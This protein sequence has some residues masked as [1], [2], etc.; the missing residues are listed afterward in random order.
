MTVRSSKPK[1]G[2]GLASLLGEMD[3][4]D[5]NPQQ[6][7]RML[8]VAQLRPGPFQPRISVDTEDLESLAGSIKASG[9][10][11]P[12]LAREDSD[13][14]DSWQIVA[15]E[16]RW[17]AAQMAGLHEVPCIIKKFSD[18]DAL[19]AGLVENL[20]RRDLDAIEEAEGYRRLGLEFNLTQEAIADLI[21]KSRAHIANAMR[22]LTLPK[23]VQADVRN[24]ALSAGHA[25]ALV[26]HPNPEQAALYI[27][28][29]GLNVRQAEALAQPATRNKPRAKDHDLE[30]LERELTAHLGLKVVIAHGETGGQVRISYR[31]LDQ[32]D[33]ILKLLR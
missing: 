30:A 20:Q 9:I 21:G 32:L 19:A 29:R 1:L 16:R 10:L 24:G 28:S 15:G 23:T 5:G 6:T 3:D 18:A 25:R 33:A 4:P 14:A 2:R 17:R 22:L 12:I 11:Q 26:T 31:D 27:I 13:L 8:P 7:I